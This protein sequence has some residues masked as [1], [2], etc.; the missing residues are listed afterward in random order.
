MLAFFA[1]LCTLRRSVCQAQH[2]GASDPVGARP[3]RRSPSS[4]DLTPIQRL[5]TEACMSRT[6]IATRSNLDLSLLFFRQGAGAMIRS[7]TL[8]LIVAL[9]AASPLPVSAATPDPVLEWIGVMNTTVLTAGTAP[10]VTSRVVALVSASVFDAVNG[11]EP[12][13]RP[14]HVKPNAP[15]NASQSAAAIQAAYAILFNLYPS[16][17]LTARRDASIA[18]LAST[19]RPEAIAAGVAWGPT[20]ADANLAL[21]V[22]DRVSPPPPPFLRATELGGLRPTSPRHSFRGS[23]HN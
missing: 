13:F 10:N 23:T 1:S 12:R 14:I 20:G 3:V 9:L 22:A 11:I 16:G 7:A 5:A 15:H 17:T 4:P 6:R 18:A 2:P 8:M 19:E 21:P